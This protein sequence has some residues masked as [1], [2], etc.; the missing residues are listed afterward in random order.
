MGLAAIDVS[1]CGLITS[2]SVLTLAADVVAVEQIGLDGFLNL[3]AAR[4]SALEVASSALKCWCRNAA[5][6]WSSTDAGD[7]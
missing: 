4:C 5:K 1:L 2:Q 7:A 3:L 6:S